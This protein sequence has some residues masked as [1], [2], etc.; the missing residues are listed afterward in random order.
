V[1]YVLGPTAPENIEAAARAR[2]LAEK[3][4]NLAQ[5]ILQLFGTFRAVFISGNYSSAAVLADQIFDLAERE[6]SSTS[7]AFAH[8][9]QLQLRFLR[10]DLVGAE[11]H[12]TRWSGFRKAAAYTQTPGATVLVLGYANFCAWCL[13]YAEKA[14]ERIARA[15]AF[16]RDSKSPFDLAI[17]RLLESLLYQW[18]REPQRAEAAA[19]QA[20]ALSEE[21]DFPVNRHSARTI[22]GWAQAQLGST[23]E[24]VSLIRQGLS[25]LAEVG[26]RV[27]IREILTRLAEAQALDGAIDDAFLTIEDA[28]RAN[29]EQLVYR[30][31][32]L[33]CRG[34]LHLK[35]DQAELAE[36]DFREAIILA[37][38]MNAK[39]WELRATTSLTRLLAKQGKR[40]EARRM[41]SEIYN[42]FTEGFDTA[43]LKDAK[44]L[45]EEL[46]A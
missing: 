29:P 24:G 33:T 16:A 14:R 5:V 44:A 23:G 21:H 39:A 10:G 38:K 15:I 8:G 6:G 46:G 19:T 40:D 41:L 12:F 20:L 18:L 30:P 17:A 31:D 42:W 3:G 22:M 36:A 13:G 37:Q 45:L 4:G 27:R 1:L 26:A 32:A 25:G 11:E 28:L 34:E 35:I 2:A 7:L 9:A 43:D